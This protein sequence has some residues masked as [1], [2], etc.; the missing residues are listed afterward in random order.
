MHLR[1]FIRIFIGFG[2]MT[3]GFIKTKR[4]GKR[5]TPDLYESMGKE[6]KRMDKE[7]QDFPG[8]KSVSLNAMQ[9]QEI[10]GYVDLICGFL[11]LTGNIQTLAT[12]FLIV[13]MSGLLYTMNKLDYDVTYQAAIAGVLLSLFMTCSVG[14]GK[15]KE[16]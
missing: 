7:L 10:F 4:F 3:A 13:E 2:F 12:F 14:G 16:D 9:F 1:T 8:R 11:L 6:F 5:W 15:E